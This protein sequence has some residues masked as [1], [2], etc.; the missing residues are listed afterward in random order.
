MYVA[1]QIDGKIPEGDA[2]R[3]K[4]TT[5]ATKEETRVEKPLA[6]RRCEELGSKED[7]CAKNYD[8][9]RNLK[10]NHSYRQHY[11]NVMEHCTA[12][13]IWASR[14]ITPAEIQRAQECHG[15][16]CH[17]WAGM[18]C[19]LTSNFHLSEHNADTMLRY[20]PMYEWWGY[21]MERNNGFLKQF[22]HNKHSGGELE[23]IMM[24]G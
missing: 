12:I 14:T 2:P 17:A 11:A 13:H 6:G 9:I 24:R 1:W 19:H 4:P 5:N 10:I 16:A 18:H 15:R 23:A 3:P 20:G 22:R 21:S 8:H 7:T